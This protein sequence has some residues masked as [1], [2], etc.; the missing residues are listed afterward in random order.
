[1]AVVW[2]A[3]TLLVTPVSRFLPGVWKGRVVH[4]RRGFGVASALAA[5]THGFLTLRGIG[6]FAGLKFYEPAQLLGMALGSLSL[7]ILLALLFTSTD[8]A[9]RRLGRRWKKLH[10]L[11]YLVAVLILLH[12][13]LVSSPKPYV[14]VAAVLVIGVRLLAWWKST[15]A[16]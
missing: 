16:R 10:R 2:L 5:I 1:M 13:P 14:G 3:L 6:W 8:T 9:M 11:V 7:G 12:V 15:S 4:L